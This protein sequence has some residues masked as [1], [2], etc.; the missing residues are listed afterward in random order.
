LI[1]GYY[2]F[3][4]GKLIIQDELIYNFQEKDRN[5][6]DLADKI[7]KK[8]EELWMNPISLETKKPHARV[9]DIDY[10]VLNELSKYSGYKLSFQIANKYDNEASINALRIM[11]GNKK[12][13]INPK[14]V[15]L[16]RHLKNA[17]WNKSKK[18]FDRSPDDGHYDC[19]DALKYMVKSINYSRNPY[20]ANFNIDAS[21]VFMY[22][23]GKYN[24]QTGMSVIDT[25]KKIFNYK[26]KRK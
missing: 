4:A 10:I 23:P 13:I 9:S 11:L 18:G 5:L 1:F 25:Y 12:I 14:C 26:G 19:V 2:D 20:P 7:A 3:K 24:N 17:K 21:S 22:E 16:I 6:Q 8:E 15:N